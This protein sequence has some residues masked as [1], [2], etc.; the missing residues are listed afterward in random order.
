[1]KYKTIVIDPPWKL[2]ARLK[3]MIGKKGY[4][5][6]LPY[7]TMTDKEITD[8]PINNFAEDDCDLFMW[9]T[10]SKLPAGLDIVKKWGFKYHVLMAWDKSGG[11]CMNGF[12]RR[13]ELIIYAYRGKMGVNVGEGSYLPTLFRQAKTNHSEKPKI[14]YELLR[15]RTREPRIDIFARKRHYGFDAYGDQVEKAIEFPLLV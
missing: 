4:H 10:H 1:M 11:V 6:N 12:Y 7:S 8:F 5:T 2:Q 14:F 3:K 13:T 15:G 9:V